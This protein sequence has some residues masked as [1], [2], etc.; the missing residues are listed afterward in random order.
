MICSLAGCK[1]YDSGIQLTI[2]AERCR[3]PRTPGLPLPFSQHGLKKATAAALSEHPDSQGKFKGR[4]IPGLLK[5]GCLLPLKLKP[6][7]IPQWNNGNNTLEFYRV[8]HR[9]PGSDSPSNK[10]IPERTARETA[11]R[12][13]RGRW[14]P[15][16]N[17]KDSS[18][19]DA[20]CLI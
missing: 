5:G 7:L 9:D 1:V 13:S 20:K 2:Q 8:S 14:R 12:Q 16:P 17:Q 3:R 18:E 15:S 6:S 4:D 11:E 10:T 19:D